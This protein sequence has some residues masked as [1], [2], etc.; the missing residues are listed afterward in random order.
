MAGGKATRHYPKI[1]FFSRPWAG[2]REYAYH[3]FRA[4]GSGGIMV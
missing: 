3:E 2:V 1:F 4:Y